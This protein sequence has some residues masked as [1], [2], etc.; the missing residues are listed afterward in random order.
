MFTFPSFQNKLVEYTG[1]NFEETWLNKKGSQLDY[2]ATS[3]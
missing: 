3:G 2:W 1:R